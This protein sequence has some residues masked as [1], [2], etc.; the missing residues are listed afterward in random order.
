MHYLLNSSKIGKKTIYVD[1]FWKTMEVAII[2]R[3]FFNK[4]YLGGHITKKASQKFI[5]SQNNTTLL[6][7]VITIELY[8]FKTLKGGGGGGG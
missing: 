5:L 4:E 3:H 2:L 8:G 7:F 6:Y 1:F